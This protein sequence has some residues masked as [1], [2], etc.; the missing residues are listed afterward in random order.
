MRAKDHQ[1][2]KKGIF[3]IAQLPCNLLLRIIVYDNKADLAV[4]CLWLFR[5]LF[6]IFWFLLH[7][8]VLLNHR[9]VL[10]IPWSVVVISQISASVEMSAGFLCAPAI[11]SPFHLKQ[12]SLHLSCCSSVKTL[13]LMVSDAF[14]V[15]RGEFKCR[16]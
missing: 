13:V 6:P 7:S 11:F 12:G 14:A 1:P 2:Y 9:A 5:A 8:S 15:C 10:R 3:A 16:L 4:N